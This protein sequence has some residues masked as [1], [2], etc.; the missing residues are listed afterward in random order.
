MSPTKTL[1]STG[2]HVADALYELLLAEQGRRSLGADDD[3][4][5]DGPLTALVEYSDAEMAAAAAKFVTTKR[6][7]GNRT[8]RLI[9]GKYATQVADI[10]QERRQAFLDELKAALMTRLTG[11]KCAIF[12]GSTRQLWHKEASADMQWS[13]EDHEARMWPKR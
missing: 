13:A 8:F 11:G 2:E 10:P 6:E 7:P 4:D 3:L 9:L 12:N 1:C 5:L